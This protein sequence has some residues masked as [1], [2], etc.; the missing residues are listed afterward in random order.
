MSRN[1]TLIQGTV[2]AI[3][4]IQNDPSS[5]SATI[6]LKNE[7]TSEIISKNAAYVSGVATIELDGTDTATVG[8][9]PYQVNEVLSGGGL[10]KYGA[11]D[12]DND[13]DC[14]FGYIIICEALDGG[15]S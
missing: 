4:V 15:I 8:I 3:D 12:C 1:L 13:G 2:A 10:A 14:D 5:T 9:Y 11:L 7:D 6:Y